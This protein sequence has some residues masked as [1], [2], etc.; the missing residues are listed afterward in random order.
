MTMLTARS[1]IV[2]FLE[3]AKENCVTK[4]WPFLVQLNSTHRKGQ[5]QENNEYLGTLTTSN[6][7]KIFF[8]TVARHCR[9]LGEERQKNTRSWL[10]R[11]HSQFPLRRTRSGPAPTVQ[12]REVFALEVASYAAV[13]SVTPPLSP[14][15]RCLWREWG[16]NT[17]NGCVRGYLEGRW[18]KWLKNG[19]DQLHVSALGGVRFN[20]VSVKRE[21]TVQAW[22]R[23]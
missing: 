18:T 9:E 11:T 12:L 6:R 20:E 23:N 17:K 7:C 21:L 5:W 10:W 13:F 19:R 8:A 4:F 22:W 3:N 14:H 1:L 2:S 15:K 16:S